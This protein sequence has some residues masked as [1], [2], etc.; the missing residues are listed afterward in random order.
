M[1][2]LRFL[3]DFKILKKTKFLYLDYFDRV[4]ISGNSLPCDTIIAVLQF[5][6]YIVKV[7]FTFFSLII[8]DL[9]YF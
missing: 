5:F 6:F 7:K 3:Y 4:R 9:Y 8:K 2:N 1:T